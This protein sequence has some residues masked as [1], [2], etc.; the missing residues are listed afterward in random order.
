MLS[1]E[2]GPLIKDAVGRLPARLLIRLRRLMRHDQLLL[3]PLAVLAGGM[4]ACGDIAFRTA[5]AVFQFLTYGS[6]DVRLLNRLR[7]AVRRRQAL[8]SSIARRLRRLSRMD[9]KAIPMKS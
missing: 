3:A 4:A 5:I 9:T 1:S 2:N 7:E 6:G 8:M